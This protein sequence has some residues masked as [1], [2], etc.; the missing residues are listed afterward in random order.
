MDRILA[1][2]EGAILKV[3]VEADVAGQVQH[4]IRAIVG[5]FL[6]DT[7]LSQLLFSPALGMDKESRVRLE[8][9]LTA[10]ME[11]LTDALSEGQMLGIVARGDPRLLACFA[12]GALKEILLEASRSER[13]REE[14]VTTLYEHFSSG[15]LRVGAVTADPRVIPDVLEAT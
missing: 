13:P 6:D 3:D 7:S 14:V 4:N 15:F 2:I 11:L 10:A 1:L 9:F 8:G 12:L 5:V